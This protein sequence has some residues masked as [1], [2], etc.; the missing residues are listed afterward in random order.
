MEQ[1]PPQIQEQAQQLQQVQQQV[2]SLARQKQ[3][4]EINSQETERALE[5]I[6]DIDK[7]TPIYKS[8]GGIMV[9]TDLSD[10]E[11]E[12]KERQETLNLRIKQIERQEERSRKRLEKLRAKIQDALQG[13]GLSGNAG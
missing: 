6:S 1:L 7:D 3:Q 5:E 12:L 10:A 11:E 9:K 8:I 13:Q 2:E 4:L